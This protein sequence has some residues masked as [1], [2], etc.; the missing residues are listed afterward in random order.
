MGHPDINYGVFLASIGIE[1][2]GK[3]SVQDSVYLGIWGFPFVGVTFK[4]LV[5]A[6][7]SYA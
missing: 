3:D 5:D 4:R 7:T 6:I 1:F 2:T